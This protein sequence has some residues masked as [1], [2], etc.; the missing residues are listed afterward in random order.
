MS[1]QGQ[2]DV[3]ARRR[4]TDLKL[5][6]NME[7]NVNAY[8]CVWLEKDRHSFGWKIY[9]CCRRQFHNILFHSRL[10]HRDHADLPPEGRG[11]W[12]CQIGLWLLRSALIFIGFCFCFYCGFLFAL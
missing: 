6:N 10:D 2:K 3:R 11:V 1:F 4:D 8:L 9:F 12:A 7:T 5:A